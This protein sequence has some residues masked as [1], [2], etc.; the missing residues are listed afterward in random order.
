MPVG[1]PEEGLGLQL[2]RRSVRQYRMPSERSEASRRFFL[3]PLVG[4]IH[5]LIQG[6]RVSGKR[7][8]ASSMLADKLRHHRHVEGVPMTDPLF[9]GGKPD[10][11]CPEGTAIFSPTDISDRT[12]TLAGLRFQLITLGPHWGFYSSIWNKVRVR[13]RGLDDSSHR[14]KVPISR[15][16]TVR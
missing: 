12:R 9:F 3:L 7:H 10:P 1:W 15:R 8:P 4:V 14:V 11:G 16:T 6:T 2:Q 13:R 5:E